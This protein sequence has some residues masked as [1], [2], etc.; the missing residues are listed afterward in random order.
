M[1]LGHNNNIREEKILSS[2]KYQQQTKENPLTLKNY[3][4]LYIDIKIVLEGFLA[5]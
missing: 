3:F 1:I 4:C 5:N 2:T